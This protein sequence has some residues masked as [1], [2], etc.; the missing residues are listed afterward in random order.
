MITLTA[1]ESE[2]PMVAMVCW[3]A[4]HW[5]MRG[6]R[7][8]GDG[9]RH[10]PKSSIRKGFLSPLLWKTRISWL[11][12]VVNSENAMP[13][14]GIQAW[15]MLEAGLRLLDVGLGGHGAEVRTQLL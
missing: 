13:L 8:R 6:G 12:G 5:A 3:T 14:D 15:V 9:R 2:E 7:Q 10:R 1:S 4:G 11:G